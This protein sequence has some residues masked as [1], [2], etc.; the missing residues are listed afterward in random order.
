[1]DCTIFMVKTY[2]HEKKIKFKNLNLK[3]M[4]LIR[5]IRLIIKCSHLA[6]F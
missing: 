2:F 1:M 5:R 4:N 6:Y 3:F